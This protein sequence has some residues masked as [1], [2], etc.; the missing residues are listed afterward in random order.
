MASIRGMSTRVDRS[1]PRQGAPNALK[2]LLLVLVVLVVSLSPIA[3]SQIIPPPIAASQIIPPPTFLVPINRVDMTHPSL[4]ARALCDLHLRP[5]VYVVDDGL[6]ASGY[7]CETVQIRLEFGNT[8]C[9]PLCTYG[10]QQH[11]R[12]VQRHI[13]AHVKVLQ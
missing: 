11:E 5:K 10:A 1:T 7:L 2:Q 6:T 3:A 4:L 12:L 13:S 8:E 9:V